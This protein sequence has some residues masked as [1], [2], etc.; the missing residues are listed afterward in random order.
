[1]N[2]DGYCDLVNRGHVTPKQGDALGFPHRLDL[3]LT[4]LRIL[5]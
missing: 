5:P 2:L 1:M 3:A 4:G